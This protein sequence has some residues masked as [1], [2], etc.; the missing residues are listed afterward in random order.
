MTDTGVIPTTC[1]QCGTNVTRL[2]ATHWCPRCEWNL[3][4]YDPGHHTPA[5][6]WWRLDRWVHRTAYRWNAR[7]FH[8]LVKGDLSRSG[9]TPTRIAV[10][11]A[12]I[13][14][15]LGV[16][17]LI[18]GGVLLIV[19]DFP[20]LTIVPGVLLVLIGLVLRPRFGRLDP[21][22]QPLTREQAPT[23]FQLI[24]RIAAEL[25]TPAPHMVVCD[26]QVNASAGA[27]GLRRRRVLTLGLPLWIQLPPQQ[28]VALLAH[29]L[30]HFSNGDVRRGPLTQ[31]AFLTLGMAAALLRPNPDE[32]ESDRGFVEWLGIYLGHI[33]LSMLSGVLSLLH[34]GLLCLAMRDSQRAEYLADERAADVAGSTAMCGVL[35]S[36]VVSAE[37]TGMLARAARNSDDV[38]VWRKA[39]A[40]SQQRMANELPLLRQLSLSDEA[41]LFAT[42]PPLGLRHRMIT[43]RPW[44]DPRVVLTE[45]E[46]LRIDAELEKLL[47]R[48]RRTIGAL[49]T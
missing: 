46:S 45:E 43:N 38:A 26:R 33:V 19:H 4:Q 3:D 24:D 27:I 25:K 6:G 49:D 7:Q 32:L 17:A 5:F 13:L 16:A 40:E 34:L 30:G 31:P 12:S 39:T 9:L 18:V 23:L 11:L 29:E 1:P 41:S 47:V 21:L 36:L 48:A 42:H 15:L 28:R 2:R 44:R 8:A 37:V 14:L 20:S 35:D 10:I 22:W